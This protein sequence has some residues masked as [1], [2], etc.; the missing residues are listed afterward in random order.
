MIK[1]DPQIQSYS[2]IVKKFITS[3][4]LS[5]LLSYHFT[6]NLNLI[7]SFCTKLCCL[8]AKSPV[9]DTNQCDYQ[10]STPARLIPNYRDI[11]G[12]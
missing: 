1:S 9:D 7:I 6:I 11:L 12:L 5:N 8:R 10:T 3:S 2:I 4:T